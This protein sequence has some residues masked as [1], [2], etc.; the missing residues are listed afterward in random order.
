MTGMQLRLIAGVL[1]CFTATT[2]MAGTLVLDGEV[3]PPMEIT[4][5]Q[6]KNLPHVDLE[7]KGQ[8]GTIYK[9]SGVELGRILALANVPIKAQL[10]GKD[11]DKFIVALGADGFGAVFS[12][13]EFDTGRFIV[14]DELDGEPLTVS[15]GPLQVISPDDARRS[16]WVKQL[17]RITVRKALP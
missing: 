5:A 7:V 9:Y 15:D 1:W 12:L 13:P 17:N 10:R 11:I 2:G 6:F 16:R 4:D 8:D 3:K 14:A